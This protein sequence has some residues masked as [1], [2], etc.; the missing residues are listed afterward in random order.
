MPYF[1]EL[2]PKTN[3]VQRVICANSRVWC[4]YHLNGTWIETE[5]GKGG[6]IGMTYHSDKNLFSSQQPYPSWI[7]DEQCV[8]HP[9]VPR[10]EGVGR[11]TWDE[12]SKSWEKDDLPPQPYP[13]WTLDEQCVWQPPV[14]RPEGD[15]SYTWNE[16]S[17]SWEKDDLLS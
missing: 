11:Y 5:T 14:P 9:P 8:W 10:P 7:L 4:E 16:E 17:K 15:G 12:E 3:E 1:A 2:N 13:S 6:G